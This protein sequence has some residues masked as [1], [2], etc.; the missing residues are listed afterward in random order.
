[1]WRDVKRAA[2][3]A[4]SSFERKKKHKVG[5]YIWKRRLSMQTNLLSIGEVAALLGIRRHRIEYA[6]TSGYIAEPARFLGKRAFSPTDVRIA[7]SWFGKDNKQCGKGGESCS[8][9]ST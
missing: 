9:S 1:L 7:A 5:A 2:R 3:F 4:F 6:I 8:D